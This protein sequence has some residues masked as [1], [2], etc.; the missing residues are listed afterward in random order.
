MPSATSPFRLA[1]H[2]PTICSE[3]PWLYT[4]AVS[5][6]LPP[7]ATKASSCWCARSSELSP[8]EGHGAQRQ[9][10]DSAACAAQRS[11]F[12]VTAVPRGRANQPRGRQQLS[13]RPSAPFVRRSAPGAGPHPGAV[14]RRHRVLSA[15]TARRWCLPGHSVGVVDR[16]QQQHAVVDTFAAQFPGVGDA[17]AELF[18]GFRFRRLDGQH[19]DLAAGLR[20]VIGEDGFQLAALGRVQHAG[21]VDHA[22]GQR[23]HRLQLRIR[24]RDSQQQGEGGGPQDAHVIYR[25]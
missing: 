12:H 8:P 24:R 1:S 3:T 20:F 19:G 7:A 9:A 25:S 5:R 22:A 17:D 23:R 11:V 18:D 16:D 4:S 14:Q 6:K 13:R 15:P 10:G 21:V 2:R